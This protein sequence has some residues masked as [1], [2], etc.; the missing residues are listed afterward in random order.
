M[1][2]LLGRVGARHGRRM[3]RQPG[4]H[5]GCGHDQG[6][7]QTCCAPGCCWSHFVPL[8]GEPD[9][10]AAFRIRC[11]GQRR[12]TQNLTRCQQGIRNAQQYLGCLRRPGVALRILVEGL[13]AFLRAEVKGFAQGC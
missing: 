6:Q 12:G 5:P 11:P 9:I 2:S 13:L 7:D 3:R 10:S 8:A 1:T 4:A